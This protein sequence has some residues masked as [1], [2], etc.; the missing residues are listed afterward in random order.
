VIFMS[1]LNVLKILATNIGISG[2]DTLAMGL[3]SA[4]KNSVTEIQNYTKQTSD[5]I[6]Y[7]QVKTFLETAELDQDD[8]NTFFQNNPDNQRLGAEI[9]KILEQTYI[10]NQSQMMARAFSLYVQKKIEKPILDQLI[11]I[12]TNL[13]QYLINKLEEYL[14]EDAI[15][16]KEFDLLHE[17]IGLDSI[18]NPDGNYT[19]DEIAYDRK[20]SSFFSR[21]YK[22][23]P[24]AL[25][26]FEFY[27]PIDM[28]I[29]MD[30]ETLPQQEYE[31]TRFFLWFVTHILKDSISK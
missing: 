10:E 23:V 8:V 19:R 30:L 31:P 3:G 28:A 16:I 15:T 7:L 29:T 25:I 2:V 6:Y 18:F 21:K 17:S 20:I 22:N 4:I 5:A 9:F 1:D 24:Q 27:K 13:N 11:Y 26:N 12:I 14:P